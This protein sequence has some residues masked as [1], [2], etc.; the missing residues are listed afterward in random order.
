MDPDDTI[1]CIKTELARPGLRSFI[2]STT[3][4]R[5]QQLEIALVDPRGEHS[6]AWYTS[7]FFMV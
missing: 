2:G 5:V 6:K 3:E 4:V 7:C 1:G